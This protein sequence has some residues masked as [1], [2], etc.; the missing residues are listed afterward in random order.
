M[1]L[2]AIN[3]KAAHSCLPAVSALVKPGDIPVSHLRQLASGG[4]VFE[5]VHEQLCLKRAFPLIDVFVHM[6]QPTMA[7][8]ISIIEHTL[9][10]IY[11]HL[12]PTA[13]ALGPDWKATELGG[14]SG[15]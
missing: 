6:K 8:K 9:T 4:L 10:V 12:L 5:A 11:I 14:W 1:G 13:P 2:K 7:F 3:T 15:S